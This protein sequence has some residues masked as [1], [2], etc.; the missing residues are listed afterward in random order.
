MILDFLVWPAMT[1]ESEEARDFGTDDD[2]LDRLERCDGGWLLPVEDAAALL[3]PALREEIEEISA[4]IA[5][6]PCN[7]EL[8]TLLRLIVD[9]VALIENDEDRLKIGQRVQ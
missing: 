4:M 3:R 8:Q 2:A 1:E 6:H 5:K 9:E 7:E